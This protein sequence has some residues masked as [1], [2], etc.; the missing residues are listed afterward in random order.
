M[1]P[2]YYYWTLLF[3]SNICHTH[4]IYIT[5][6]FTFTDDLF[7]LLTR[8]THIHTLKHFLWFLNLLLLFLSFFL[9]PADTEKENCCVYI[10]WW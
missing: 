6:F 5:I 3:S 2:L 7:D 9:Q 10:N 4:L 8:E 1:I